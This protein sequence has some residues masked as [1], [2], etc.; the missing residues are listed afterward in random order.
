MYSRVLMV[1]CAATSWA[2]V[3]RPQ[4]E[5]RSLN[6]LYWVCVRHYLSAGACHHDKSLSRDQRWA[7]KVASTAAART[8]FRAL[9]QSCRSVDVRPSRPSK[10]GCARSSPVQHA[11]P[12]TWE[13]RA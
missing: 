10:G 7:E 6:L 2:W 4:E 11:S 13:G 3:Q 12:A 5:M 1:K 8:S 9:A